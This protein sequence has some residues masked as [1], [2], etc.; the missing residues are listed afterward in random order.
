MHPVEDTAIPGIVSLHDEKKTTKSVDQGDGNGNAETT[1]EDDDD[2]DAGSV[3]KIK[4]CHR[5]ALRYLCDI[6]TEVCVLYGRYMGRF[7]R[8]WFGDYGSI[9]Q[10]MLA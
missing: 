9:W 6:W 8:T 5:D 10:N 4:T 3:M 2:E 1:G 7:C